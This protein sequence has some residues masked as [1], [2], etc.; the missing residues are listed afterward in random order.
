[1]TRENFVR[2]ETDQMFSDFLKLTGGVNRF[3]H[4][5]T[6]TPLDQQTVVRMNRDTLYSGAIIDTAGGATITVPPMSDGR[7]ASVLRI[8]NDHYTVGV[9]YDPG[10][11]AVPSDTRHIFAAVRI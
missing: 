8:D 1:M 10:V 7:Y 11:H 3:H 4:I 5:R 2:A 9:L 6:P